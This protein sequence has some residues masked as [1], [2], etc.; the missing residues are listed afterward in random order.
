MPDLYRVANLDTNVGLWY[1]ND[2]VKT[3]FIHTLHDARGAALPM[4]FD[5][6]LAG[7]WLS[8][9]HKLDELTVWFSEEDFNELLL[10]GYGVYKYEVEDFRFHQYSFP[11]VFPNGN[12]ATIALRHAVFQP[13]KVL[14][15]TLLDPS[16]LY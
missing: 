2:G 14:S 5:D 8:A 7:G 4:D 9:A 3:D 11:D 16:V 15:T 12:R 13:E 10:R 1:N 6:T